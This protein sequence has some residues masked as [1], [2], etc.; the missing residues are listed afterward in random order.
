MVETLASKKM[1]E[2][3]L[4]N[5]LEKISAKIPNRKLNEKV[6]FLEQVTK[7]N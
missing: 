3:N 5:S 1:E 7:S 2:I 6:E 4:I